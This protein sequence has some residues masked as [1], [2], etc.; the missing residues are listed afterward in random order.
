MREKGTAGLLPARTAIASLSHGPAEVGIDPADAMKEEVRY[1]GE[2]AEALIQRTRKDTA[3]LYEQGSRD[4]VRLLTS[5]E[6]EE[7]AAKKAGF[8]PIRNRD[9]IQFLASLVLRPSANP[10]SS[11]P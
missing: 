4:F 9:Y 8:D 7:E 3:D 11:E 2:L 10:E 5:G 6:P 1:M